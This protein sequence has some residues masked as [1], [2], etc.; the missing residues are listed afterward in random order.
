MGNPILTYSGFILALISALI[1]L[2]QFNAKKKLELD[3]INLQKKINEESN[4]QKIR[5]ETYKEYLT[6]LDEINSNLIKNI[7]SEEMQSGIVETIGGILNN[8]NDLQPVKEYFDK[9]IK[10]YYG[11]AKEQARNL[12]ELNGLRLV[13]SKEILNLLND[14]ERTVKNYT[15]NVTEGIKNYTENVTEGIKNLEIFSN[16]N[17]TSTNFPNQK[18]NYNKIVE[19]RALIES[20]MRKDIGVD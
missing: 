15:E 12:E 7:S 9:M 20:A 4:K 19:T 5:Y 11:W 3:K 6:K 16:P 18:T 17:L 2:L 1:A 8:P 10:F 14:Y 13:C